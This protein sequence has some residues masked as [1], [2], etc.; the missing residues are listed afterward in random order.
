[1]AVGPHDLSTGIEP[2]IESSL[3]GVPWISANMRDPQNKPLVSPW[4]IVENENFNTGIIGLTALHETK[5]S[6]YRILP[7]QEVLPDIIRSLSPVCDF[8]ILLSNMT[9]STNKEIASRFPHI[10]LIIGAD[11]RLGNK[12]PLLVN[13]T[14]ITQTHTRGKY[15]GRFQIEWNEIPLWDEANKR[16]VVKN[17]LIDAESQNAT[18]RIPINDRYL[19]QL[20]NID[21][22]P[23]AIPAGGM[24]S[25]RFI[26]LNNA[27]P[28]DPVAVSVLN[29][30][31]KK[32]RSQNRKT[33]AGITD[34]KQKVQAFAGSGSCVEC[35][36]A[37]TE[38]WKSTGHAI[39]YDTL[40]IKQQQYNL[41]CLSCH[42]TWDL[43]SGLESGG[44]NL[45]TLAPVMQSVGCEMCH[46]PL[47]QHPEGPNTP[48]TISA[49]TCIRCHTKEMDDTFNFQERVRKI[50]CPGN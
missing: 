3:K 38:F 12:V 48:Y 46:G 14:V 41:N 1:M 33:A 17:L 6:N 21:N 49:D 39:A 4:R 5:D 2:L 50:Q 11:S 29:D 43:D 10:Q 23:E 40:V 36:Q 30:M 19:E 15:F 9:E 16:E 26:P 7:W 34:K 47:P 35:H 8:L 18:E 37:Q 42:V 20:I 44:T 13:N 31:Q 32:I 25:Y 27:I 45:L 24:Y 22:S 28:E